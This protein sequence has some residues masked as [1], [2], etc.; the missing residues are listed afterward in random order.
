LSNNGGSFI[1]AP[2]E[3]LTLS[4][5]ASPNVGVE[6]FGTTEINTLFNPENLLGT[7]TADANGDWSDAIPGL[8]PGLNEYF[9]AVAIEADGGLNQSSPIEVESPVPCYCR[10]TLIRTRRS[11]KRVENLRVGDLVMTRSGIARPVKWIGQRSYGGR[12]VMGRKD[13]L[14]ICIKAGA[15]DDNVPR[16]DLWISPH[17]AMYFNA[18]YFNAMHFNAMHFEDRHLEGVLIEAKDL[19]NGVS[20]VQAE[21]PDKVE[22]F[23]IE[24][25]SH[26]VIIAEGAL[27]ETFID[28]DSRDIFHNAHEYRAL[29][30]DAATLPARYCAPRLEDGGEVETVRRHI[31]LRAGLL[32]AA[33]P[34]RIGPLRGYVDLASPSCIA[35]WAQNVDHPEAPVCLDIYVGGLLI[36]QVLAN[37]YREDLQRAGLGNGHHSFEFAPTAGLAF[38]PDTV[39]VR[40]SLDGVALELSIEARQVLWRIARSTR[41]SSREGVAVTTGSPNV[42]MYR[43]GGL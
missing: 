40:R 33:D 28:D 8:N 11:R 35:G 38:A 19:V 24:L 26:D 1:A 15:L 34:P 5:T 43:Q 25:E 27:S 23:H 9:G 3:T 39:E 13:I 31:A 42:R 17:H 22:Y 29:Y 21:R 7:V 4:G 6:L 32:R 18:T 36:G 12:F 37:R 41:K 2:G 30:P 10:G 16:R 20:I 14:P